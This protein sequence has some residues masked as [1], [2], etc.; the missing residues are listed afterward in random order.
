MK[1]P[2]THLVWTL[3][4]AGAFAG[5]IYWQKSQTPA[6]STT[7]ATTKPAAT[8]VATKTGG[9]TAAAAKLPESIDGISDF[10]SKYQNGGNPLSPE[11]MKEAMGDVLTESDPVKS[12]LMFALLL[13]QL[14]S[15]NAP[16]VMAEI[17]ARVAGFEG[18]RYYG[19]LAYKWGSV[20]GAGALAEAAKQEGPARMMSS[21]ASIA[22][23]A[24][25]DPAAA[26]AWL[27]ANPSENGWEKT[28]ME[29]G[30]VSGLART[31]IAAAEKYVAAITDKGERSRLTQVI[32]EEKLKQGTDAAAAWA[33]T[34]ADPDMKKGAFES[35]AEQLYRTD[36]TKAMEYVKANANEAHASNAA[37]DLA[38]RLSSEDPQQGLSFAKDLPQGASR[39]DAYRNVFR[40]WADDDATAASTQLNNMPKG[41]DR[42]AA[43]SGLA[44]EVAREDFQG[45][46]AWSESISDPSL[47]QES[48]QEVLQRNYNRNQET[49]N[50]YMTNNGWTE[51][52]M[53]AVKAERQDGPRG[54]GR[55][56]PP[57]GFGGGFGRGR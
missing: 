18:M 43:A 50:A 51:E 45:A 19:L 30:L 5:G 1:A 54:G 32:M 2:V 26:Q 52:Q 42:D 12:S 46:L 9:G 3:A 56:G 11:Q 17:R 4:A 29:R 23:W 13:D 15:E 47:K 21:I 36:P 55:G 41:P 57:G 25:K 37:G 35:V 38:R 28:G 22:G 16:T 6:A 31:D 14:S 40:E 33:A 39:T 27:A 49:V 8:T 20:D 44:R 53:N 7:T 34:I 10:L 24:T 48:L